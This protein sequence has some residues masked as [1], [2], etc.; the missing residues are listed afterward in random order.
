M[1]EISMLELFS[2]IGGMRISMLNAIEYL[3]SNKVVLKKVQAVDTSALVN[4]CYNHNFGTEDLVKRA[5]IE[6]ISLEHFERFQA[7]VWTMSPP[8]Q[9][10]TTTKG[11]KQLGSLDKRNKAFSYIMEVLQK[12]DKKPDFIFFENVKGFENTSVHKQFLSV[13]TSCGYNFKQ[14]KLSPLDFGVPMNRTRFYLSAVHSHKVFEN[15]ECC[16]CEF[17]RDHGN[18]LVLNYKQNNE[19]SE[20]SFLPKSLF[21]E[22]IVNVENQRSALPLKFFLLDEDKINSNLL[23]IKEEVLKKKFARGLSYVGKKDRMTFCFTSSYGKTIHKSS[24]SL[25]LKQIDHGSN[26]ERDEN[27]L[28]LSGKVRFFDPRELLHFFG[29]PKSYTLPRLKECNEANLRSLYKIIGQGISITVVERIIH[30]SL[31]DVFR[32]R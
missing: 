22:E 32:G 26:L 19:N 21:S 18:Y 16:Q 11:S 25:Y 4:A 7:N 27:M 28:S 20:D 9:P 30:S 3:S 17:F 1:Y 2:G 24:G 6:S 12:L 23:D 14:Y 8:C 5:N 31:C 29:F 10:F 13:L 15:V